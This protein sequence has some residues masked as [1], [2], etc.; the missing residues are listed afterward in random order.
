[1]DSEKAPTLE[2]RFLVAFSFQAKVQALLDAGYSSLELAKVAGASGSRAVRRWADGVAARRRDVEERIDN[3]F[4]I[5]AHLIYASPY[6]LEDIVGWT[7]S[8]NRELGLQRPIAVLQDPERFDDV[9]RAAELLSAGALL[10]GP[11]S[12]GATTG[13]PRAVRVGG[14]VGAHAG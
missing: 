8:R 14:D 2:A 3:L 7:R 5:V 4:A 1:M 9:L 13:P 10:P 11:R 12:G 6:E